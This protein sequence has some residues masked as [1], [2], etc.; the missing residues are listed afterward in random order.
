[1]TIPP[2][3]SRPQNG[4]RPSL[5][6]TES[7][8]RHNASLPEGLSAMAL[9]D[10]RRSPKGG[11]KR[12]HKTAG[13]STLDA[14]SGSPPREGLPGDLTNANLL[15]RFEF[16]D[17]DAIGRQVEQNAAKASSSAGDRH[18]CSHLPVHE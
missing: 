4:D 17:R 12:T 9:A 1:M 11:H 10:G 6:V 5:F 14:F 7:P 18:P 3:K 13:F 2:V 15:S 16:Q 8:L